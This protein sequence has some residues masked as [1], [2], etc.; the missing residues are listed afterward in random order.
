MTGTF[1]GIDAH[2]APPIHS[3]FAG[4]NTLYQ[5]NGNTVIDT[6]GANPYNQIIWTHSDGNGLVGIYA[7]PEPGTIAA[8]SLGL[9]TLL[10][11]KRC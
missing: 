11:R 8:I 9:A 1:N 6:E 2:L 10:R 3:L 5:N 4:V 7:V